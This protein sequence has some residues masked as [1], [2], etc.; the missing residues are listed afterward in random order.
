[1]FQSTPP[2]GGTVGLNIERIDL[3]VFQSTPRAGG[4]DITIL[5]RCW[6]GRVS[7]HAPR[8]GRP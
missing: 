6:S 2:R 3:I 8:G 4:D 5:P 7:I 1:M